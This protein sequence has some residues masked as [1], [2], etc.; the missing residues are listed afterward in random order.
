MNNTQHNMALN[1]ATAEAM[2]TKKLRNISKMHENLYQTVLVKNTLRYIQTSNYVTLNVE[3]EFAEYEPLEKKYC[4]DTSI[5]ED[6]DIN[7]IDEILSEMFL[8]HPLIPPDEE[9]LSFDWQVRDS[10]NRA[11]NTF[12]DS[13]VPDTEVLG[14]DE[15]Y[16]SELF[17]NRSNL[18][19]THTHCNT[20]T[21][22]S[23]LSVTH[24]LTLT[25]KHTNT[26]CNQGY[27]RTR[28]NDLTVTQTL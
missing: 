19:V 12:D 7:D 6:V 27:T 15:D 26:H 21:I 25:H 13:L 8:P 28:T 24:S 20:I 18:T 10:L 11:Y 3:P 9:E 5:V 16:I 2:C 23:D 4:P 1:K 14:Y 22:I 17:S